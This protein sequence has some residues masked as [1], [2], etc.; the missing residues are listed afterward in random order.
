VIKDKVVPASRVPLARRECTGQKE[1]EGK[2]MNVVSVMAHQDDEMF[3][4]GTMLK[5]KKRGDSLFFIT[6]TDGS[7]GFVQ[8][9]GISRKKAAAIRHREMSALARAAGGRYINLRE[10]D[11][12]LYDTPE[13]RLRL[14][15]ALRETR[16]QLVFT[17][18]HNDY[19][20]DHVSTHY[21]V[22]QCAMHAPL[23]VLRTKSKPLPES[24]AVFL[25]EPH[26]PILFP[27]SHYTD[28]SAEFEEKAELLLCHESQE[29]AMK[30]ALGTGIKVLT[31]RTAAF[32]GQ[33]VGCA[34]A[35][36]FCPMEARGAIKTYQ[37]LP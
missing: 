17:H 19:N 11:E 35:E 2:A 21:L 25:I 7:K 14:I 8:N 28:I 33:Q 18:Y 31:A 15:E 4:L 36:C 5:C 32:R 16:A 13:L 10:H 12:F 34:Y 30:A 37:V 1:I 27:A 26:G 20:L 23:P 9:P 6:I 24:P 29:T 3:C 22:K